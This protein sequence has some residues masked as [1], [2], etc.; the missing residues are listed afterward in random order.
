VPKH[1]ATEVYKGMEVM[2]CAFQVWVVSFML[3]PLY[4]L[5]RRRLVGPRTGL[6]VVMKRKI[7]VG[8]SLVVQPVASH[9]TDYA[10]MFPYYSQD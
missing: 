4:P 9:F 10:I 2:L 8:K 7:P 5:D 1:H 3:Q 6:H